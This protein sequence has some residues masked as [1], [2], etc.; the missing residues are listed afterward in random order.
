LQGIL[1]INKPQRFT[2]H[3]VVAIIRRQTGVKR[4]GHTGTLDPMATGVLP[5]CVGSATRI[6]EYLDDDKKQYDCRLLLGRTTDTC[7]IWGET[8]SVSSTA[9]LTE[10]TVREALAAQQGEIDQ[11]PPL[12]SARRVN[13][14]RLYQYARAGQ[15]VEVPPR[16]VKIYELTVRAVHLAGAE[17]TVD[18]RVTCSRGTYLR[19][20]C[21][22]AGAALGCGGTM[23]AL[24]R[25][26]SGCWRIEDAVDLEQLREM[27]AAQIAALLRPLDEPLQAFA[28]L[29]L[30][31]EQARA[32]CCGQ[33]LT[34]I[35]TAARSGDEPAPRRCRVYSGDAFLG[36]G[37]LDA[38]GRLQAHKVFAAR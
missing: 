28:R 33:P 24:Q 36:V 5:V 31:A 23:A 16:R 27:P 18:F 14:R 22:D 12:Y 19:S 38:R 34:G 17:A 37:D 6:I 8:L 10:E 30:T 35:G 1:N 25:T 29:D 11:R 20:I 15:Q 21:R 3:D 32:F 2:S 26:A 9:D 4:V 13:G 7:D